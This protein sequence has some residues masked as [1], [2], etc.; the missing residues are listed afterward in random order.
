MAISVSKMPR[1]NL[2]DLLPMRSFWWLLESAPDGIMIVDSE[3]RIM[4]VNARAEKLFGYTEDELIDKPVE[5]LMPER[6]RQKHAEHRQA[7]ESAPRT[8]PMG[9][10]LELYGVRR[11][12]SDFP[13][14]ISLSPVQ[15]K[16]GLL[17]MAIIRDITDYK[18]EHFIS[19]TLQQ[20]LLSPAPADLS[21]MKMASAYHSAHIGALVGGD[22]FDVFA[23]R[24]GLI[25]IAIGDVSGKG[26]EASV[27]TAL[28]KYSLRAYAYQD[29]VPCSVMER[30]NNAV[31]HQSEPED[32]I[33]LF[34]G[35]LRIREGTLSF[36]NA[37]HM[38]PLYL[39][40]PSRE[41]SEL[42][43]R[44]VP[45]GAHPETQYQ[46]QAIDVRSG[47]RILFY[48][49]G[50][51]DARNGKGF[52]GVDRL[53]EFFRDRRFEQP[54]DFLAHLMKT[55]EDWSEDRL[56]DDIALLLVSIGE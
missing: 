44:G 23:I 20:A 49:D 24:P 39:A 3:G 38:P 7:Y 14:E 51:T 32:F 40:F 56:R 22:F 8:R 34:Y 30:L 18:R 4:L 35:L 33:T 16:K 55:L 37:G 27:H 52:Y 47:D 45:L 28:A 43:I 31:S 13:V 46:Q 54:S 2:E 10:G 50:A 5:I 25:G 11:D 26:T 41:V 36:A 42:A 48:T 21:G 53:T 6:F 19:Q 29:P 1:Q 17:V 9:I 12:G 15:T